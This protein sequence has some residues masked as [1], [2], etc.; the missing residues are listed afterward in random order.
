MKTRGLYRI[1]HGSILVAFE[2]AARHGNFAMAANELHSTP[3]AISRHIANLEKQLAT[4]LFERSRSGVTLTEA[5][6]HFR[7]A[8]VAG[9]SVI[10]AGT[11]DA[12]KLSDRRQLV[13]A[14]SHDS[15]HVVLFPWYDALLDVLGEHSRIRLL[16]YRRDLKELPAD[17]LADVVLTWS[18]ADL[19]PRVAT[20][21]TALIFAEE[22]QLICSP[23]YAADHADTL[24]GPITGWGG[25]CF[26][27]LN[28]PNLGWASWSDW[29]SK[30]GYP[31]PSPRFESFDSY[32]QVLEAASAGLGIALGWRNCMERYLHSGAVVMLDDGFVEFGGRVVAALTARGRSNPVARK[33]LAFFEHHA[34]LQAQRTQVYASGSRILASSRDTSNDWI[35]TM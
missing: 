5:G 32:I 13:I 9:L 12:A 35:N 17:P 25:L 22:V 33:C 6:C 31:D 2:S 15:S 7:D 20:E 4:K 27:D 30:A 34:P 3:P 18:V 28:V 24:A 1:P 23:G 10:H 11:L 16:T 14:C 8:V 19:A 26:L 21:D 29:F